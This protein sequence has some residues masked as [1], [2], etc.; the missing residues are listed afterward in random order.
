LLVTHLVDQETLYSTKPYLSVYEI[1][2]LSSPIESYSSGILIRYG[3]L[4]TSWSTELPKGSFQD[5][6]FEKT[7]S[8]AFFNSFS[9]GWFEEEMAKV[10]N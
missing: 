9:N 4:V 5:N 1:S 10:K 3:L 6:N 2:P 8:F 7:T